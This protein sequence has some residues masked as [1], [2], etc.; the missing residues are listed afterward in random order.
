[1]LRLMLVIA[2]VLIVAA[3]LTS[4]LSEVRAGDNKTGGSTSGNTRTTAGYDVGKSKASRT[5]ASG[6]HIPKAAI[7][8]RKGG[9]GSR[10][11]SA[12][13]GALMWCGPTWCAALDGAMRFAY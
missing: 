9:R 11:T 10:N 3:S 13:L 8:V 1:M 6:N 5:T 2:A 12:A 4:G 7:T